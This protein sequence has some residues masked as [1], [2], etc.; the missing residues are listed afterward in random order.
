[1]WLPGPQLWTWV[2]QTGVAGVGWLTA[3]QGMGTPIPRH[4]DTL[5]KVFLEELCALPFVR[6]WTLLLSLCEC[7][8]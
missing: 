1:M 4:L 5:Q 8:N 3:G 6:P 7:E 2:V